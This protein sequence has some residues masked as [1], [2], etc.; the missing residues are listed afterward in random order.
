M[1]PYIFIGCHFL[2]Y[3]G[4][5]TLWPNNWLLCHAARAHVKHVA[6][7]KGINSTK[8]G[9]LQSGQYIGLFLAWVLAQQM[10]LMLILFVSF[11]TNLN[12]DWTD[13]KTGNNDDMMTVLSWMIFSYLLAGSK[14]SSILQSTRI[15]QMD[16]KIIIGWFEQPGG[17][18]RHQP[19]FS[20]KLKG[21]HPKISEKGAK[22]SRKKIPR[23]W[24]EGD[25]WGRCS[26]VCGQY[27]MLYGTGAA[28]KTERWLNRD[29]S[30]Q[31][32]CTL[33]Q[34]PSKK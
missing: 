34:I 21:W 27:S 9:M 19:S 15:E 14:S 23:N 22:K 20:N 6:L 10:A 30:Q 32:F 3:I 13:L 17:K 5:V 12:Y 18:A 31:R 28:N 1:K 7:D 33:G 4:V 26:T 16:G 8:R 2:A 11:L 25:E 29:Q 24:G